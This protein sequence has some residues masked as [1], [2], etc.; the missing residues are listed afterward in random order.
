LNGKSHL[1]D[2]AARAALTPQAAPAPV[3]VDPF[4]AA[5][6]Y[7]GL[8]IL[9]AQALGMTMEPCLCGQCSGKRVVFNHG[10][11]AHSTRG[12]EPVPRNMIPA[13]STEKDPTA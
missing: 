4:E 7:F 5:M 2:M 6:R 9:A 1:V 10:F 3:Q 13:A 11:H 8:S 12:P